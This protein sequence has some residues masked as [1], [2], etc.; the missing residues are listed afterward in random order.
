MNLEIL[1][2]IGRSK[3]LFVEDF[4]NYDKLICEEVSSSAFLVIGGAG[5]IGGAVER[6]IFKRSPQKLH[7]VEQFNKII[8][9]FYYIDKGKYLDGKM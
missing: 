4:I 9:D 1:K 6:E 7:I 5:S 3:A 8:P 2:L